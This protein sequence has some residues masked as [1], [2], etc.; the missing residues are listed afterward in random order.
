MNS[1]GPSRTSV[2]ESFA[3]GVRTTTTTW[4]AEATRRSYTDFSNGARQWG[5]GTV[6][7]IIYGTL[8]QTIRITDPFR[9]GP[10]VTTET[11][12]E[13]GTAIATIAQEGG[14][15]DCGLGGTISS[16]LA[17]T[18]K[19]SDCAGQNATA[20]LCL[21]SEPQPGPPGSVQA[22]A[23]SESAARHPSGEVS[24]PT[25]SPAAGGAAGGT[26][27]GSG[28]GGGPEDPCESGG[29]EVDH[30]D[31]LPYFA[32]G[33]VPSASSLASFARAQG[34]GCGAAPQRVR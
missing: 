33:G 5:Q 29:D 23:A 34:C 6:F 31:V 11:G 17:D 21:P 8:I 1:V 30:D 24:S 19:L 16:C 26:G 28:D 25:F 13:A 7:K 9:P 20:R 12:R 32:D 15:G 18:F 27:S 2:A 14:A 4:W 22:T 3:D 10:T